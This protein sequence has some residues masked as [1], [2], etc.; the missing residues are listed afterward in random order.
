M[1]RRKLV[2]LPILLLIL[3]LLGAGA[4]SAAILQK[5]SQIVNLV[6]PQPNDGDIAFS[7]LSIRHSDGS[8]TPF[9]L[10]ANTVLIISKI[11]WNF[12]PSQGTTGSCN[13]IWGNTTG[14][15]PR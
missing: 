6:A 10:P 14:W 8:L 11:A 2:A 1:T 13:S 5:G 15:R 12:T 3:A 4:A 7:E 9:V